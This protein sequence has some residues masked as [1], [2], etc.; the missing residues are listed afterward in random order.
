ME[1]LRQDKAVVK[2]KEVISIFELGMQASDMLRKWKELNSQDIQVSLKEFPT[3]DFYQRIEDKALM[4]IILEFAV[5]TEQNKKRIA[6]Q[7]QA[8]GIEEARR[9]GIKLGRREK[10]IPENF[11]EIYE[12][13]IAKKITLKK[14]T[15]ILSVDYK[16]YKK[17]VKQYKG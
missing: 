15:A 14:A 7:R 3:I 1:A 2:S 6:K 13:V 17:W 10:K 9:K 12:Q 5:V 4:E 16:T 11:V 8:K